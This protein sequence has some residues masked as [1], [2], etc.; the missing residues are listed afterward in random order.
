MQDRYAGDVGDF[1]KIGLLR[2]LV[3]Q[4]LKLA[5]LWFRVPDESHNADG[6]HVSYLDPERE[7][8]F[9]P[10]DPR[11]YADLR[12]LRRAIDAKEI[13]R[14]VV[15]LEPLFPDGTTFHRDPLVFQSREPQPARKIR[16]Q[17]WLE[18]ATAAA[19]RSDLIFCDPD[20]G[21]APD[22]IGML[23]RTSPKYVFVS[24]VTTL[25]TSEQSMVIY[26]HADRSA[27]VETQAQRLLGRL[28][29][30]REGRAGRQGFALI[31]RRGTCRI[32]AV[33]PAPRHSAVLHTRVAALLRGRWGDHFQ[34][35][36]P[37]VT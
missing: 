37:V 36:D 15:S 12:T 28:R 13:V 25:A 2:A 18:D 34:L 20:N 26:H 7:V 16:R 6:K 3:G 22:R 17:R 4:D 23:Q 10:C 9:E 27:A 33:L 29:E 21:V 30:G 5:V 14:E 8:E 35:V 1:G 11:L 32:Y 24:D 31:F 19:S